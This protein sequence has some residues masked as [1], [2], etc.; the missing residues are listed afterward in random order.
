M[1]WTSEQM[2]LAI[3]AVEVGSWINQAALDHGIPPTTLKDRTEKNL[4]LNS[5]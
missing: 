2:E 4:G 1:L 5:T 3:K